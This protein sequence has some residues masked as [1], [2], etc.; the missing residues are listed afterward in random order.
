MA[1]PM[2]CSLRT[3]QRSGHARVAVRVVEED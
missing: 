3:L 1:V 2:V